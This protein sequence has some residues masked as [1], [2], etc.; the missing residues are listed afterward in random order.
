[1]RWTTR[2]EKKQVSRG[3]KKRSAATDAHRFHKEMKEI[4]QRC[5]K[6]RERNRREFVAVRAFTCVEYSLGT[7]DRC[8]CPR[9]GGIL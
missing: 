2:Q 9:C 4:E 7:G 6:P 8:N 1:M 5:S 3:L